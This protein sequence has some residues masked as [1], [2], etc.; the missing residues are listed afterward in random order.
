MS[1]DFFETPPISGESI[2]YRDLQE[3]IMPLTDEQKAQLAKK[4]QN[5]EDKKIKSLKTYIF[6]MGGG[7]FLVLILLIIVMIKISQKQNPVLV[8]ASP[9]PETTAKPLGGNLTQE[10]VNQ[11][12]KVEK[13]IQ[14]VDLQELDLS[15]PQLDFN[16]SLETEN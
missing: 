6:I 5:Q 8:G 16:I 3:E 10:M 14:D 15:Y 11:V 2:P 12:N 9:T 1:N 13:D 7:L 4:D